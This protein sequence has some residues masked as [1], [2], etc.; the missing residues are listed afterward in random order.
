MNLQLKW[1]EKCISV[2]GT[3]AN[4]VLE[5]K[6]TDTKLYVPLVTLSTQYNIKLLKQLESG[7]KRTLNCDKYQSK[8]P[9]QSQ[10]L[11]LDFLIGPRFH[12]LILVISF[13]DENGREI[14]K[15]CYLPTV[16]IKDYNII[17]KQYKNI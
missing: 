11:Y 17:E 6:I 10:N 1:F 2:N 15:Q 16:E 12:S 13:E 8:K 5:F 14:Y 4:Q 3:A 7:F 9:N